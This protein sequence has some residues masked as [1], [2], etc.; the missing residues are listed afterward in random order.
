MLGFRP[1]PVDDPSFKKELDQEPGLAEVNNYL[2]NYHAWH[3]LIDAW[4]VVQVEDVEIIH[5]WR[6]EAEQQMRK[7]KGTEGSMSDDQVTDF[8][9]R[10]LPSYKAFI[11][12]PLYAPEA[13]KEAQD[14]PVLR[15]MIDKHRKP[16]TE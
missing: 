6:L 15:F 5:S 4:V 12:P 11:V 9:S 16:K 2:P 1:L 13:F 7:E 10:F 3:E 14:K 8:V